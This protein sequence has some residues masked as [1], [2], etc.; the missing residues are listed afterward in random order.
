MNERTVRVAIVDN[1]LDPGVYRPVAHWRRWL[2][3][4]AEAFVAREGRFPDLAGGITHLVLTGSEASILDRAPWA[5]TEAEI[6]REAV[7]GGTAVL[8]S[9][10][11]HQLMAY[12][13]AGEACVR[14]AAAPEVG[15]IPIR[16]LK[17]GDVLGT[18]GTAWTFAVHF[19]EV[20]GLD[21]RFEV[22]AETELCRVQAFR[23][24]GRPVWGIQ[25]HPEIDPEE[26]RII[27]EAFLAGGFRAAPQAEAALRAGP[28]D[29][30]LIRTIV[31]TFLASPRA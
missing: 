20:T 13:L 19:D 1:A 26:G 25:P 4:P 10:W 11:G 31:R 21:A 5:E 27:L 2:D 28:R 14:R 7:A 3:V 24:R 22:L 9:C 30:G 18:T 12:A 17:D 23:L 29:S 8:G 15:W 16:V 6:V